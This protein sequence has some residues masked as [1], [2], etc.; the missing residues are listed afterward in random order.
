MS[1][2]QYDLLSSQSL[3][4]VLGRRPTISAGGFGKNRPIVFTTVNR[5]ARRKRA[6]IEH[7]RR[8]SPLQLRDPSYL[9][10]VKKLLS[11]RLA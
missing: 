3:R 11:A 8:W 1:Y 10:L 2:R 6:E 7:P 4:I 5:K 9:T